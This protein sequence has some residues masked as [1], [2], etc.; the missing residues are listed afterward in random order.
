VSSVRVDEGVWKELWKLEVP[1]AVKNFWWR[2]CQNVLPTKDNLF[3]KKI[4]P[5]PLCP[6]CLKEPK[7]LYHILWQC[8]SSMA[9]WQEGSR[10]LQKLAIEEVDDVGL[11]QFL[12]TKLQGSELQEALFISRLL[13]MRRNNLVFRGEFSSPFQVA[14]RARQ[15]VKEF[16][17]SLECTTGKQRALPRS[18][19]IWEK[20][21]HGYTKI[22]WDAA[23]NQ[24]LKRMEIGIVA[25]DE[26]GKVVAA[27]TKGF[28]SSGDLLMAEAMGA[29]YAV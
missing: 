1:P 14:S 2:V 13:W 11:L 23:C 21:Q 4:T 10:R 26:F 29:W 18:K 8:P 9:V 20:P 15:Q 6:I 27:A 7:T 17:Q 22:N 24:S 16:H 28:P 5:D 19:L 12:W 25:R 3:S